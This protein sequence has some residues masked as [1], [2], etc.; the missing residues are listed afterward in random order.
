MQLNQMKNEFEMCQQHEKR[1]IEENI[2][3][4]TES[5]QFQQQFNTLENSFKNYQIETTNEK[6]QF[7]KTVCKYT[8]LYI[9]FIFFLSIISDAND[10]LNIIDWL[11]LIFI[12]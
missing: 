5:N 8:Y 3:L 12:V 2:K 9:R 7:Q 1:L 10:S 6:E 11:I 4:T